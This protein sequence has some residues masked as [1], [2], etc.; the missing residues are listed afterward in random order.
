MVDMGQADRGLRTVI[1][2]ED[3]RMPWLF[4]VRKA[5]LQM[6]HASFMDV[7][8]GKIEEMKSLARKIRTES[9]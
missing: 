1:R 5:A 2:G 3:K 6:G 7:P 9:N 4:A 8:D